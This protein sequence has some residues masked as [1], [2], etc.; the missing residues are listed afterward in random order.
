MSREKKKREENTK[1]WGI[2]RSIYNKTPENTSDRYI[3]D[4][5]GNGITEKERRMKIRACCMLNVGKGKVAE[6]GKGFE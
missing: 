3:L 4:V 1:R 2:G 5:K 6:D